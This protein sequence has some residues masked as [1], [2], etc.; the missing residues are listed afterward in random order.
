MPESIQNKGCAPLELKEISNPEFDGPLRAL[1]NEL[2]YLQ[3][4]YKLN[5]E[6]FGQTPPSGR[7]YPMEYTKMIT[8][9]SISFHGCPAVHNGQMLIFGAG[10]DM[11]QYLHN[12][13]RDYDDYAD[14]S[15]IGKRKCERKLGETI[16]KYFNQTENRYSQSIVK[17]DTEYNRIFNYLLNYKNCEAEDLEYTNLYKATV[18][19]ASDGVKIEGM[20]QKF[21]DTG[22]ANEMKSNEMPKTPKQIGYYKV[23]FGLRIY[24]S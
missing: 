22:F 9:P 10:P 1:N 2:S 6:Y 21:Y 14:E 4:N 16:E 24:P 12:M 17:A 20:H 11:K 7:N 5:S 15:S 18:K 13:Y 23:N 19:S 3:Q 8:D